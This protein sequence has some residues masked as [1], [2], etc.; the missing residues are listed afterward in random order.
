MKEI[1][2]VTYL[3]TREDNVKFS[4]AGAFGE[5]DAQDKSLLRVLGICLIVIGFIIQCINI[6]AL[7]VNEKNTA[8]VILTAAGVVAALYYDLI[9]PSPVKAK[10]DKFYNKNMDKMI[11]NTISVYDD[12]IE[13]KN[14]RYEAELPLNV[15]F[16]CFENNDVF[17]LYLSS[18][19]HIFIP[20]RNMSSDEIIK[21]RSAL[22][23][24]I[25]DYIQKNKN[26][27]S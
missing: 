10:A 16:R 12:K 8:T 14:Y 23:D 18:S 17:V 11:T 9:K 20:K 5:I 25:K 4:Q 26:N 27:E 24:K 19:E 1:T 7:T 22:K 21:C 15:F 13:I 6:P 3:T 2:S